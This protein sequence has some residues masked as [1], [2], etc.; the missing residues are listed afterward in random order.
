MIQPGTQDPAKI[1]AMTGP[2]LLAEARRLAGNLNMTGMEHTAAVL[3]RLADEIEGK[4]GAERA[5]IA[6]RLDGALKMRRGEA[7]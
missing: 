6:A 7:L 2:E 1:A 3:R 5:Y 4:D